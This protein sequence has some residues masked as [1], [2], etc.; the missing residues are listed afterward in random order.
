[1]KKKVLSTVPKF[2]KRCRRAQLLLESEGYQVIEYIGQEVMTAEEIK[3]VGGDI[4]G[5]IV[6]CDEWNEEIFAACPNLKA[7]GRFGI[8]VDN[9]DL[10]AAKRHGVKVA[11]AR[12]MNCDSVGEA[13]IMLVL[14]V[15]R[16][17]INLDQTT[18]KGDWMRYTGRTL[19]GKTYGL[20]GF[21]AIAQYVAKILSGFD[22]EKIYAYDLYP[23]YEAAEKLGV[24]MTDFDTV[25]KES[26]IISLHIPCTP[27]TIKLIDEKEF[28]SMKDS[29]VLIN[30]ARG[31]VV[32]QNALY[33]ALK[34]KWIAGAGID[35]FEVEPT[36]ADNPLFTLDNIVIM[37]HQAGDT[38]ETFDKVGYFAAQVIVDVMNGKEPVNWLNK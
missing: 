21:G 29:A 9:I 19:R 18:R 26:D 17:L 6:G 15:I 27:E 2:S 11:N 1:M 28:K 10:E 36:D 22:V 38:Y 25:I 35:V 7:I 8:G 24:T 32:D 3:A 34:E 13:T 33:T 16:N 20:I 23:N 5:A 14:A 30:V 12:G 4:C 37:P 31:P